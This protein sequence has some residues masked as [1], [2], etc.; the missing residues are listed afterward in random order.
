MTKVRLKFEK[1]E[2]VRYISHLDLMRLFARAIKRAK[3]PVKFSQ[4]FN[5]HPLISIAFPLSVGIAGNEEYIDF[6]VTIES[7]VKLIIDSLNN[8]LPKGVRI[9][10]GEYI[11]NNKFFD[12]ITKGEYDI[13]IYF[14]NKPD[15]LEDKIEE[16]LKKE[17]I[18]VEKKGKK[19][20]RKVIKSVNI[21]PDIFEFIIE[22]I[23]EN[24]LYC[25]GVLSTG[26]AK[27]L[28]PNIFI[29]SLEKYIDGLEIDYA[30]ITRKRLL[31]TYI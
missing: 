25:R 2:S 21:R 23:K 14:I 5:P 17:N 18:E 27:T 6:E 13:K 29:A 16:Y 9:L 12:S 8:N 1:G 22:D 4:G 26:Q 20:G 3:V 7:D 11:D 19:R 31:Q 28:N 30:I 24:V 10:D 15:D